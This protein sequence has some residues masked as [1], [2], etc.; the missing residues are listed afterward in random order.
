MGKIKLS[1]RRFGGADAHM[2]DGAFGGEEVGSLMK[3]TGYKSIMEAPE[4]AKNLLKDV[5]KIHPASVSPKSI[6]LEEAPKGFMQELIVR[7]IKI[8]DIGYAGAV[9]FL[10]ALFVIQMFNFIGGDFNID[11]EEK[12]TTS[13][14]LIEVIVR[15]WVIAVLAYFARNLFEL[16]PFPLEG[17]YGYQHLRVKE[18]TSSAIFFSFVVVFD[19]RLQSKVGILKERLRGK[20]VVIKKGEKETLKDSTKDTKDTPTKTS[21]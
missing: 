13:M 12:K 3:E 5:A 10:M 8:F 11:E 18:V 16:V 19:T 7:S 15:I 9:Y 21:T 20:N 2:G 4:P 1:R 6:S 14:L 17:V